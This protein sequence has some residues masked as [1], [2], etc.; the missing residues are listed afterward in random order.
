MA[1]HLR[2]SARP[3]PMRFLG[4]NEDVN[5]HAEPEVRPEWAQAAELPALIVPF[6]QRLYEDVLQAFAEWL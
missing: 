4:E 2:G 1:R 6:K 5:C 3:V